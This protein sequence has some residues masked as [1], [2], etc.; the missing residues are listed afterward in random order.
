MAYVWIAFF[1]FFSVSF[2]AFFVISPRVKIC[3][4]VVSDTRT[5]TGA[6]HGW[7]VTNSMVSAEHNDRQLHFN[8]LLPLL[9]CSDADEGVK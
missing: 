4:V 3:V 5:L 9:K 1:L 8:Y 6:R 2:S 7:H